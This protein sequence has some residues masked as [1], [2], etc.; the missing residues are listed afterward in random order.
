MWQNISPATQGIT[1]QVLYFSLVFCD[2]FSEVENTALN[3]CI[4]RDGVMAHAA[5]A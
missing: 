3:V 5:G 4:E 1:L 2:G